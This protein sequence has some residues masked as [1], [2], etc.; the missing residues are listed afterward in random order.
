M[1]NEIGTLQIMQDFNAIQVLNVKSL[2][3]LWK[4]CK[5]N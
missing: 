5:V 2:G 3:F 4:V 1:K